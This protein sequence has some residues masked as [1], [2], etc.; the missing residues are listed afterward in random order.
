MKN[1]RTLVDNYLNYA[2]SI[3]ALLIILYWF[4]FNK[5][6]LIS[7]IYN[8]K[9]SNL[10]ILGNVIG[11][12]VSLAGFILASLTIIVAIRSNISNKLPEQSKSPLELFFSIGT[13]K[14]IVKV[15]KI[16]ITELVLCFIISYLVWAIS[17]NVANEFIFKTIISLIYL[18]SVSTIRS[19]FVLFLLI[20]SDINNKAGH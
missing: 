16:A 13:F 17:E 6:Y 15:F 20:N 18:M 14:T 5:F 1:F 9:N 8:S 3:D 19:L 4:F 11:A 10:D 12:S 2:F 7:I